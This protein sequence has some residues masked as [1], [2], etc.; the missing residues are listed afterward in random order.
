MLN[1]NFVFC[2]VEGNANAGLFSMAR[3][4]TERPRFLFVLLA[5]FEAVQIPW[6]LVVELQVGRRCSRFCLSTG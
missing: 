1:M 4:K 2:Q 3:Q 6:R 5:L